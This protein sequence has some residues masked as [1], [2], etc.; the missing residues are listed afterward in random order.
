MIAPFWL[1][2]LGSEWSIWAEGTENV[3]AVT[4]TTSWMSLPRCGATMELMASLEFMWSKSNRTCKSDRHTWFSLL[5]SGTPELMMHSLPE[6]YSSRNLIKIQVLFPRGHM[7]PGSTTGLMAR[8][9]WT[10]WVMMMRQHLTGF[11]TTP[12]RVTAMGLTERY[13]KEFQTVTTALL[14]LQD[15]RSL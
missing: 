10:L 3:P 6:P 7:L 2:L 5:K 8:Q 9:S 12:S 14:N 11:T 4:S 1:S 13:I 15:T